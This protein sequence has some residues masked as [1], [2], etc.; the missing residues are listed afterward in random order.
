MRPLLNH[1]NRVS[2][3]GWARRLLGELGGPCTVDGGGDALTQL[4]AEQVQ[5]FGS[6]NAPCG[7]ICYGFGEFDGQSSG[8]DMGNV[9]AQPCDSTPRR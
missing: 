6:N 5:Q 8:H 7:Y 2:T 1:T 4:L 3:D 9:R